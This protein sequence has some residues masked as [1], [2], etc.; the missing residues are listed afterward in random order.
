MNRKAL[1]ILAAA[2]A[3]S[4]NSQ[5]TR[6]QERGAPQL[7]LGVQFSSLTLD[8]PESFLSAE[9]HR[10]E[11]GFGGRVTYNLTDNFAV[12]GEVNFFPGRGHLGLR[13]VDGRV[14][15]GQFGVKVGKRFERFG[16]FAKVRPGVVAF[17]RAAEFHEDDS[18][19]GPGGEPFFRSEKRMRGFLSTDVGGVLEFY[20]SRR[21]VTRFDF[22]DTIIR[23]GERKTLDFDFVPPDSFRQRLARL[24]SET[25]HNFQFSAGVG[26]RF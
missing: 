23:Y 6:A 15:Q 22:G 11:P 7:E 21:I 12:E 10:T 3:V 5:T 9:R 16:L 17:S 26:F 2:L 19:T 25:T 1:V 13:E 20:P 18:V 8:E 4:L 24:P 14:L